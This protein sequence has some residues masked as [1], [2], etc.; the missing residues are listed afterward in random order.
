[1]GKRRCL[2]G[3][4]MAD[5]KWHWTLKFLLLWLGIVSTEL[6][7]CCYLKLSI[8]IKVVSATFFAKISQNLIIDSIIDSN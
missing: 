4:K 2:K 6:T 8:S 5:R 7:Y 3:I 1:M